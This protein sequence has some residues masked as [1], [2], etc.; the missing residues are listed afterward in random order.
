MTGEP[1]LSII[2][3][4]L[5]EAANIAAAMEALAPLRARGAEIIG[6][7]GGID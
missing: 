5:D 6:V 2:I 3:P 4:V 1:S 7:D